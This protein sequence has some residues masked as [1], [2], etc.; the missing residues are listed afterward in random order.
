MKGTQLHPTH[1][2]HVLQL[3]PYPQPTPIHHPYIATVGVSESAGGIGVMIERGDGKVTEKSWASLLPSM[4]WRSGVHVSG[5]KVR[6][7]W[8]HMVAV[9]TCCARK[10]FTF[11]WIKMLSILAWDFNTY[12]HGLPRGWSHI[13]VV[14]PLKRSHVHWT[15]RIICKP[16]DIINRTTCNTSHQLPQYFVW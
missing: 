7:S 4:P 2:R 1:P 12:V 3:Y 5:A 10:H 6:K 14:I 15:F 16:Y 13:N 8:Y 9:Y 11:P